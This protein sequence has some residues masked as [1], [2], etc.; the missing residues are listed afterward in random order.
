M[1]YII[2]AAK[3][4][5]WKL[6]ILSLF[7]N[8][9]TLS[10]NGA[11]LTFIANAVSE[12]ERVWFWLILTAIGCISNTILEAIEGWTTV[13]RPMLGTAMSNM[14]INKI[15]GANIELFSKNSPGVVSHTCSQLYT[16]N[17]G[18]HTAGRMIIYGMEIA[19][20]IILIAFLSGFMVV[21]VV[22]ATIITA[23]TVYA[24]NIKWE[25]L[26]EEINNIKKS[27]N[28]ELD[29]V[30][31]G[32][33]EV[34]SF[35]GAVDH[36]IRS[37]ENKNAR[38]LEISKKRQLYVSAMNFVMEI[39]STIAM[40]IVLGYAIG[41]STGVAPMVPASAVTLVM[42]VWRLTGPM[43]NMI[44]SISELSEAKS[45]IPKFEE[46]M[47][48]K[49]TVNDGVI[50]L[51]SFD[52][53]I[54]IQDVS[55]AYEASSTVLQHCNLHIKKGEHIGIC[56]PSG[57]GKTSLI[58]LLMRYYD[59]IDGCITIDGIDIRQIRRNSLLR[60]VGVVNQTTHIFDGSLRDNIAYA[61]QDRTILERELVEACKKAA[62]LDFINSLPEGFDTNV[63]PRGMKLSGGQKQ[64]I[65]LARIFL[66]NPDIILLDEATSALDNETESLVQEAL[67]TCSDKTMVIIA[68]RL[69]T[70]RNC[71]KIY[72][73]DDHHVVESGTHDELVKLGGVYANMLR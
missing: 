30:T 7:I 73:V 16:V 40:F 44:F 14:L 43:A 65:S 38:I 64:R 63:G 42:Y 34:R 39:G 31:N 35:P 4:G 19:V 25:N 29:E 41:I 49:N 66:A 22:F 18:V 5:S 32:Y 2:Q 72:V 51:E 8:S 11:I 50:D 33:L 9:I 47:D 15:L 67:E 1:K 12:P 23:L 48:F 36:H 28:V 69:S 17:G 26:D 56:G 24:V 58:K 52:K 68:H 10:I 71:D 37:L 46:I 27:R 21:P 45:I 20:N 53:E 60:H 55:F 57:G 13:S 59:V 62:I 61:V 6:I 70:I 3:E 54:Y